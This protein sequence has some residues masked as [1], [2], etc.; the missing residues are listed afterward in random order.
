MRVLDEA[1][2]P[3]PHLYAAGM[4]GASNTLIADHGHTL[5]WPLTG[6]L[7]AGANASAETPRP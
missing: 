7:I 6:G 3:V 5:S 4:N 1:G 2:Q